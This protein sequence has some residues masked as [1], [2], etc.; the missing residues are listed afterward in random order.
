MKH[1]LSCLYIA[2]YLPSSD[3]NRIPDNTIGAGLTVFSLSPSA[4]LAKRSVL[5]KEDPFSYAFRLSQ[6]PKAAL[7]I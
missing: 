6:L 3:K 1:G 5:A 7:A 4:V 2:L